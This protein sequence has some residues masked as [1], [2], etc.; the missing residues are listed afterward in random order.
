M[1]NRPT[2]VRNGG[3]TTPA[4]RQAQEDAGKTRRDAYSQAN[5]TRGNRR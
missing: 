3:A 5:E 1:T 2:D 4:D